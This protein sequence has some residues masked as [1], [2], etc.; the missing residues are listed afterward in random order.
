LK[1][2]RL[3]LSA[4]GGPSVL[5]TEDVIA[6]LAR[7][8]GLPVGLLDP[9]R[10]L[11]LDGL[12][13]ALSA[14]VIGQEEA[15]QCLVDR[16]A[17]MKAGLSDPA[18]PYGVFL[19]AGPTGTGKT[20]I[21]KSLAAW[22]FGS[23]NRLIRLDMSELQTAESL[24]RLLGSTGSAETETLAD[25][26]RKQPFSVILLD[27][28]EKAHP[29][30]WDLFLQIFDDARIT[31]RQGRTASFRHA[32]MILTTNL[33]A[34]IPTGLSIGFGSGR[35][36]FDADEVQAA[37]ARAFRREFINRLDRVIIF[38]P[39]DRELMR[40]ILYR[41][42]REVTERRGLKGRP[43]AVEW[44]ESAIAFLLEK[45]FTPDLGARP[46]R[47]AVERY[48][49]SPLA[50]TIVRHQFPEGDQFLFVSCAGEG[51]RVEFV[52]PDAD[53]SAE[54]VLEGAGRAGEAAARGIDLAKSVLLQNKGSSEDVL[55]LRDLQ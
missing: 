8:T 47:R 43:W 5:K 44:D 35:R 1:A 52:D 39:L 4:T 12:E 25:Q 23:A 55:V 41:E 14:R 53:E 19:F 31:D 26:I 18:R 21:A 16:V 37:I 45:G 28:F 27:E 15:V 3:R 29:N 54:V 22:L 38:R 34:A 30:V 2:T 10:D 11:N 46:L 49:L 6:T 40:K 36:H 20:E 32:I 33:G 50:A 48:L 7:Q 17:M 9:K 24:D 51:L 42:L 13:K